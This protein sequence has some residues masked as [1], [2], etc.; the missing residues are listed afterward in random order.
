MKNIII[1]L[2]ILFI[3]SCKQKE[4][5]TEDTVVVSENNILELSD[6]QL[7]SLTLSDTVMLEKEITQTLKLNG[8][9]DVPPQNLV[10]VSSALGG[11][12]KS[13]KL[14]PGMHFRK[15]EVLAVLEDNQYIHLQQDYLTTVAQL[16]NSK[17][18]YNRQKELNQSKAS[19]DKVYQQSKLEYE[20]LLITK[21]A[22]EEKLKLINLIPSKISVNNIQR[23]ANIYAPFSGY[24]MDI[25]VNTCKYVSPS[26][27]LF[28][29]V[30]PE[31][32]HLNLKVFEKNLSSVKIGQKI[33]AYTNSDPEKKYTGEIVLIG[34]NI[35]DERVVEAHAHLSYRETNLIPGMY[36]NAEIE[37]PNKKSMALP[38]ESILSFEG[39]E[40]VFKKLGKN[41]F[42]MIE[43]QTGSNG[44]GWVEIL[45]YS[46]LKDQKIILT[47]AY[48]LLMA[49]KNK[50]ED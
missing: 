14:L 21:Q 2:S 49:L 37:V 33:I 13:I 9:I 6:E 29:L 35:S 28:E 50:G 39:N 3:F 7:N 5:T 44:N 31:D 38:Q 10:S 19:S 32:L 22:L 25:N 16:E 12:V 17:E 45:N 23:T 27:I 4:N 15:G 34:K 8:K 46:N 1:L 11:Y 42:E 24:V 36:M 30:N 48:T 47:G 41:K 26:D 43:V 20:T 40:Y 18:E